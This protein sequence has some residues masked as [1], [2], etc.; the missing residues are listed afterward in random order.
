MRLVEHRGKWAVRHEG[1]RI[2]TGVDHKPENREAAEREGRKKIQDLAPHVG[3]GLGEIM[4]AYIAEKES[5]GR[6]GQRAK[7]SWNALKPTFDGLTPDNITR[8][9]CKQYTSRRRENGISDG[10][11]IRDL[12]ILKAAC[13]WKSPKHD[14]VFWY[15]QEPEPR[16]RHLT[17]EEVQRLIDCA[18]APHVRL[19][20]ELAYGTAAR[21]G[22]L[23]ELTWLQVTF[24]G[25]GH[26]YLG[27]KANGKNRATVPMTSRL[28]KA[29]LEAAECRE[30]GYVLEYAGEPIKSVR[31]GHM[32][33]CR[34]AGIEDFRIHDWRHT[35]AVHMAGR[36]VD[37]SKIQQFLGHTN[38]GTTIK[39]YARYQPEALREAA[40]ALE[41]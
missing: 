22:A 6:D 8:D 16:D 37:M 30:T 32:A 9:L 29:L 15:P 21:A 17:T 10:T 25:D 36:G 38:I 33:A 27:R 4:T 7:D 26:I 1:R 19:F 34:R 3:E 35:S 2:S 31:T 18:E 28:R 12:K 24:K 23:Y 11:I 14:G 40:D 5:E 13:T 39:I 41:L 20:M